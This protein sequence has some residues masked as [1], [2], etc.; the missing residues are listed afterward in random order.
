MKDTV[1]DI[2]CHIFKEVAQKKDDDL[3]FSISDKIEFPKIQYVPRVMVTVPQ[4][5]EFGGKYF[6]E[7]NVYDDYDNFHDSIWGLFLASIYHTGSHVKVSDYTK[8]QY[9]MQN[10]TPEKGWK[11]I[12]FVE[13]IKVEVYLKN[14]FP[15][16]WENIREINTVY[17]SLYDT[18]IL[19]NSKKLA[20]EEFYKHF[21][22]NKSNTISELKE[23]LSHTENQ[24]ISELVPYLDFLYKNIHLL[25]D[26]VLPYCE[27]HDFINYN[28]LGKNV[29]NQ[30]KGEFK[31]ITDSIDEL[32]LK[33]KYNAERMIERY[34]KLAQ[35]LKFD[36]IEINPE[37]FGEYLRVRNESSKLVKKLRNQLKMV[38][39]IVN[40]PT[41]EDIGVI[42]MQKAIQA[43][44]SESGEIQVFEQ[45][46]KSRQ[47][48][49]WIIVFDS[50]ASMK[51]KFND[52][53]KLSLCLSETADE[54][55]SRGGQW[56]MYSFNNNF[57]IVKD[58]DEKYNQQIKARLGGIKNQ[59]LSFIPDAV[60]MGTR[61][62]A[63]DYTTER[64]YLIIITDGKSLGYSEIDK[65]FKESLAFAKKSGINIIGIGVPEGITK[66]FSATINDDDLRKTV[67]K[68]IN[69][70]SLLAQASM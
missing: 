50:S 57:F 31:R 18:K 63:A 64:K 28:K 24:E 49:N 9:W 33:E 34:K 27:H 20:K 1:F 43:E 7:G 70:Y 45:D 16:A 62:L 46:E 14:F 11:V 52:M 29:I 37:N 44:A 38:S 30:P 26:N 3:D 17:N 69:S 36:E 51:L 15:E 55:N 59:G 21:I 48:E 66:L 4:P 40:V 23:K 39:N 68:F 47:A 25:P 42:E 19:K 12:D 32:W 67:A 41:S 65:N 35:N 2:A 10:K 13:D 58:H 22:V 8:Y 5:M 61:I 53:K 60:T 56:G 54:L 6:F